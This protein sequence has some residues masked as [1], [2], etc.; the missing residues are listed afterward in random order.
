[1]SKRPYK[2]V[3]Q[4]VDSVVGG[5]SRL[6]SLLSAL[7]AHRLLYVLAELVLVVALFGFSTLG[8]R[9]AVSCRFR[10]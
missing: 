10:A 8:A 7:D 1:M 4:D 3:D 6:V 2:H 9:C 5:D